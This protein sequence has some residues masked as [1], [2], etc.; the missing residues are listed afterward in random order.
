MLA[1]LFFIL[2]IEH[3]GKFGCKT[4]RQ[5]RVSTVKPLLFYFLLSYDG[6]D[7]WLMASRE[8]VSGTRQLG[9]SSSFWPVIGISYILH[10]NGLSKIKEV[11]LFF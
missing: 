9:H 6:A 11:S 3:F 5:Q 10:V 2:T 8:G 7:G 1:L 4:I